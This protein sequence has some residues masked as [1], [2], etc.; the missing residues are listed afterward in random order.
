MR[1]STK[2][3]KIKAVIFD[4]DGTLVDSLRDHYNAHKETVELANSQGIP[5]KFPY[6]TFEEWKKD[7]EETPFHKMYSEKYGLPYEKHS[8]LI[9]D[10]FANHLKKANT[11]TFPFTKAVLDALHGNLK[12]IVITSRPQ[13]TLLKDSL[14]LKIHSYFDHLIGTPKR[15]DTLIL[16]K[17][18]HINLALKRAGLKPNEVVMVGDV[19]S[20]FHSAKKAH[21]D[22]PVLLVPWGFERLDQLHEIGKSNI[23]SSPEDLVRRLLAMAHGK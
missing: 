8:K 22:M 7:F 20:D 16:S 10:T 9:Y 12:L 23:V 18:D 21:P 2:K 3:T 17:E 14:R 15:P 19:R 13:N 6:H 1:S 5:A 11:Q 4:W